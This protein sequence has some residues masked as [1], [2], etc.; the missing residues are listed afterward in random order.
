MIESYSYI[1]TELL[2]VYV[3]SKVSNLDKTLTKKFIAYVALEML[4]G[5]VQIIRISSCER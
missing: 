2:S 1:P 5:K 4:L 3:S